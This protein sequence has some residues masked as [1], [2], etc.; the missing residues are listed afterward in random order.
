M[1]GRA[2]SLP[3]ALT[4]LRDEIDKW[5]RGRTPRERQAVTLVLV[6]LGALFVWSVFIQPALRSARAAPAQ[7]EQLDGALQ[8][9]QRIAGESR[10]LRAITPVSL[11]Q[12]GASLKAASERLGDK[13]RLNLQGDRATLTLTGVSPEALRAWLVEARSGARARPVEATLQRGASGFTG[14]ISLTLGAAP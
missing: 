6:V 12:A 11:A 5:W 1:S 7:L 9:M 8:Q 4:S 13:A 2:L 3:P 10:T 14:S